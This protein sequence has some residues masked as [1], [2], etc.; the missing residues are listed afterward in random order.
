LL[1]LGLTDQEANFTYLTG[2][3][4]PSSSVLIS[5]TPGSSSIK[6]QLF[7]PPAA[8]LETI[9]SV[10]PPTLDEAN[11]RFD[12]DEIAHTSALS[13]ALKD[14]GLVMLHTLPSTTEYPALPPAVLDCLGA[15]QPAE[16]LFTALHIA[17]LTKDEAEIALIREANR[18][19]SAA[20]EV[21]M[22]E[23]GR[24]ATRRE[25]SSAKGSERTRTG[26]EGVTEWQVE[27]EG[28]GEAVFTAACRRAG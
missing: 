6:H 10:A 13:D 19:S 21:L 1:T 28:D 23:L 17:R 9:W 8:P 5:F 25:A 3:P 4:A 18:I 27:S 16:H 2:C 24:Y 26:K 11:K 15:N 20:H 12:S 14:I 7:I 22:R